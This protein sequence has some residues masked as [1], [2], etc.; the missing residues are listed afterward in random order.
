MAE[1]L[2]RVLHSAQHAAQRAPL[3]RVEHVDKVYYGA[4]P[5]QV[6]FDI[7]LEVDAGEF[8]AIIGPSGSG[9]STLLNLLGALDRPTRGRVVLDG[10]D[11]GT[12]ENDELAAVRN[13]TLGFVFQ[14][15]YLLRD[16]TAL[17]NVLMPRWIAH[18][19]I[20]PADRAAALDV[21]GRVGLAHHRDRRASDL[22][23]GEQQRVAIARALAHR[24]RLVLAD[25][26]TGNLD[27]ASGEQVFALMREFNRDWGT[28][29]LLITHDPRIAD[30]MDRRLRIMD[31][32][33]TEAP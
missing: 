6:L 33:L 22:S 14:F 4:V 30:Q 15:H 23:G 28:T 5:T 7:N 32:R 26:P 11:L 16:F 20:Q 29:F 1:E 3:L 18:K 17:E 19:V 31:G 24:P 21:L 2:P 13:E 12:L 9:K 27:T 25:E 10:R 8:V